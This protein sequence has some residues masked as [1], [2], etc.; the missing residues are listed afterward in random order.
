MAFT[1][2]WPWMPSVSSNGRIATWFQIRNSGGVWRWAGYDSWS[3][4]FTNNGTET[5]TFKSIK[6]SMCSCNSGGR[7]FMTTGGLDRATGAAFEVVCELRVNNGAWDDYGSSDGGPVYIPEEPNLNSTHLDQTD[8][9]NTP[10]GPKRIVTFNF[11]EVPGVGKGGTIDVRLRILNVE[12]GNG[13]GNPFISTSRKEEV[14][15][16]EV[17]P[18]EDPD[19]D[20]ISISDNGSQRI[21][22]K[23][24]TS[25]NADIFKDYQC[26]FTVS[27]IPADSEIRDP[28]ISHV[29]GTSGIVNAVMKGNTITC[30]ATRTD[31]DYN[32]SETFRLSVKGGASANFT[33]DFH[34]KPTSVVSLGKKVLNIRTAS[35]YKFTR[36][37][38]SDNFE[39]S[40]GQIWLTSNP[41]SNALVLSQKT[42]ENNASEMNIAN[43]SSNGLFFLNTASNSGNIFKINKENIPNT[44]KFKVFNQV[45][46]NVNPDTAYSSSQTI[47]GVS[48]SIT[49]GDIK[50][51]SF[52]WMYGAN[53]EVIGRVDVTGATTSEVT[54]N[55]GHDSLPNIVLLGLSGTDSPM[56]GNLRYE[57]D[58]SVSNAGYCRGF[59]V[60]YMT[61]KTESESSVA[62]DGRVYYYDKTSEPSVTPIT[63]SGRATPVQ[64]I[65]DNLP[66]LQELYV[67]ITPYFYFG[68]ARSSGSTVSDTSSTSEDTRRYFGPS[69]TLPQTFIFVNESDFYTPFLFPTV[70]TSQPYSPMM[71]PQVERSGHFIK[72]DLIDNRLLANRLDFGVKLGND[73]EVTL[74]K[75]SEY[76][77]S[78]ALQ[79]HMIVNIG[80]AVTDLSETDSRV[81]AADLVIQPF[82]DVYYDEEYFV[83]ISTQNNVLVADTGIEGNTNMTLPTIIHLDTR[84]ESMWDK[85]SKVPAEGERPTVNKGELIFYHDYDNFQQFIDK[86]QNLIPNRTTNQISF[87]VKP[88]PVSKTAEIINTEFWI[89]IANRITEYAESMQNWVSSVNQ[90]SWAKSKFTIRKGTVIDNLNPLA[91]LFQNYWDLL[92][93][94]SSYDSFATHKYLHDMGYTHKMLSSFTHRQIMN[95]EGI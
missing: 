46:Q 15:T 80:K 88:A 48:W 81:L 79:T 26:Q 82:I 43:H 73:N 39:I 70:K 20:S 54:Y 19:P 18:P 47:E 63:V 2:S 55:P 6:F 56:F 69:F 13:M 68:S 94:C 32:A 95:K 31:T 7:T 87:T 64:S 42:F 74:R 3:C 75:N 83:R 29:G 90:V 38:P 89:E 35:N 93:K 60:E 92:V 71:L 44:I 86:Y 10:F 41:G 58:D 34:N 22:D 61:S 62:N 1:V 28:V 21:T 25:T 33:V 50:Q 65:L 66:R 52:D 57:N 14:I 5:L 11:T 91:S 12:G 16:P 67:R 30:T 78:S 23:N 40:T 51:L 27:A 77:S 76:F 17:V 45:V 8:P 36:T 59:R 49:P 72:K 84:K 85:T 24:I 4:R 9:W 37:N 53:N